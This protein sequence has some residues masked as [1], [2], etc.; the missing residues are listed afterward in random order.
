MDRLRTKMVR[1]DPKFDTLKIQKSPFLKKTP[2]FN[3]TK[4]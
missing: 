3:V 2:F 1:A 4:K